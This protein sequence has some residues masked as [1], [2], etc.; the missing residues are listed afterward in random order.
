MYRQAGPTSRQ[1]DIAVDLESEVD[2]AHCNDGL[3]AIVRHSSSAPAVSIA[4]YLFDLPLG[5]AA[6]LLEEFAN[7]GVKS[8]L[9]HD[10]FPSKLRKL[11]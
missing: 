7:A 6:E 1:L 10:R 5:G 8:F 3:P 11:H 9:V 2:T 4:H